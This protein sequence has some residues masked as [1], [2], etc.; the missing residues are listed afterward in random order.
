MICKYLLCT[1]FIYLC[2]FFQIY[3]LDHLHHPASPD[4]KYGTLRIKFFDNETIR[5]LARGDRRPPRKT[6]EP[7]GYA[8]VR[9]KQFLSCYAD[10]KILLLLTVLS[11][12]IQFRSRSETCYVIAPERPVS[13]VFNIYVPRIKHLIGNKLQC[14]PSQHRPMF[15]SMFDAHDKEVDKYCDSLQLSH[16]MIVSKQ[17][18]LSE[19]FGEM[20]DEVLRAATQRDSQ[21]EGFIIYVYFFKLIKFTNY[22][23]ENYI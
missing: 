16:Q 8:E 4:N 20:I 17:I 12:C 19:T 7:F 11:D 1:N 9:H 14:L 2:I 18:E 6:G 5:E 3:Y 21:Q 23:E 15:Q 10:V 13:A 22:C